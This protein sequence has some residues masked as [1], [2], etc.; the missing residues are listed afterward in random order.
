MGKKTPKAP[1]PPD[2]TV[3]SGAQA[4]AN[5]RTAQEQQRLNMVNTY[6][7]DGSVTYGAD[8]NAPG[9]YS[10][11][12]TLSPQQ[13][14]ISNLGN[15][16]N[17]GAL[18]LAND[19]VGR[20]GNAL[21]TPLST[22]GLP[23]LQ[24]G[25]DLS[26]MNPGQGIQSSFNQ[27]GPL[28]YGFDQGQQV[29]GQVGGDLDAARYQNMMA[30][31]NQA[32][33]R[34]DPRFETQDRQLE[35]RLANQGLSMNSDAY[36]NAR[37]QFGRERNDAYNQAAYS[38]IGAGENAANSM[39]QRQL[40]Q[41]QF[42]N[43]AAGQQYTQNMGQAAFNNQ[44]AGQD[45]NQNMGAAT[46]ANTAQQQQFAQQQAAA[47]MQ[48]Q[49]AQFGNEAR[50][51]GL[52]E[53][54]YLQNQP[55]NQFSSLMSGSQV[56]APQG[57]QYTPSQVG[58]TDVLGAYA[59]NQQAQQSAYQAQMANRGSTLGGLF[60]LGSAA[61]MGPLSGGTSL[62]GMGAIVSD[63]RAKTDIK[64]VGTLDNGVGV[65]SYRYKWG[66]PVQIGVM[67]Q[68]LATVKPGAVHDLGG[69]LAVDYGA[70]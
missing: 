24:G 67:A 64:R 51:Q 27:G 68:E 61:L 2:P 38:A 46:F 47:Q 56:S 32:A 55:I 9:G 60:Q 15:Q 45:Y 25:V 16:A 37:D 43:Q 11:T 5:I 18:G 6:G 35:T 39:F 29:Q 54:A 57:I 1:T 41:G 17:I 7:P 66:G 14:Q 8:P 65:Y 3:V 70:I 49:N 10:Q 23:S 53:R 4:D 34:L 19:Q 52:Q 62:A 28:Q 50:N 69:L 36:Q 31:Y 59:L 58:Q 42:A 26:G 30:T 40:G 63:V 44:T 12:T 48:M 20:I 21:A 13:Q 22:N 33:S